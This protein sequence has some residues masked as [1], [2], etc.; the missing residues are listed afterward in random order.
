MPVFIPVLTY[1]EDTHCRQECACDNRNRC[2]ALN[3]IDYHLLTTPANPFSIAGKHR[4]L[5]FS[6]I[7]IELEKLDY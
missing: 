5:I 1:T 4:M 6:A 3:E 2:L 7:F